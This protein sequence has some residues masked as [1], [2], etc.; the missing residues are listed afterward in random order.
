MSIITDFLK[1][2]KYDPETDGAST[3]NIKQCL[4]DNWDKIDA[5]ASGIKTTIAGLV[6]GTRKINNKALSTDVTLTGDDIK[7]SATDET[8]VS[9]SLSNLDSGKI[10]HTALYSEE[11]LDL[12]G[13]VFG[14][15]AVN[16]AE[17]DAPS[18]NA[19]DGVAWGSCFSVVYG[20]TRQLLL[21]DAKG[22][23]YQSFDGI[24]WIPWRPVAFA[25]KPQEFSLPL[26]EGIQAT[27]SGCKYWKGQDDVCTVAISC[28]KD[29]DGLVSDGIVATLPAGFRPEQYLER[30][31]FVATSTYESY[32]ATI[33]I[34][35]DGQIM[36]WAP[37]A[38]FNTLISEVSFVATN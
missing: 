37:I 19:P 26:A 23:H 32:P 28:K 18:I 36:V 4:N 7:T 10:P 12:H 38:N 14:L 16:P 22:I 9:S 30:S 25:V 6:P 21:M 2:F 15:I 27:D 5:W 1:L 20:A 13:N 29:T 33:R 34:W 3:F 35:E 24:S 17:N 11:A 8:T 31:A